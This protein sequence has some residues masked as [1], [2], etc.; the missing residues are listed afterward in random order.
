MYF[1]WDNAMFWHISSNLT[2]LWLPAWF[3]L[4]MTFSTHCHRQQKYQC[5]AF[6]H[7]T[8]TMKAVFCLTRFLT[9]PRN[10]VDKKNVVA[11]WWIGLLLHSNYW[12][13]ICHSFIFQQNSMPTEPNKIVSLCIQRRQCVQIA[14]NLDKFGTNY[15]NRIVWALCKWPTHFR[16]AL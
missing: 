8:V 4:Q 16:N 14:S 5:S 10:V 3:M 12:H 1:L 15:A 9:E 6:I 7:G 13:T 11:Y 2:C